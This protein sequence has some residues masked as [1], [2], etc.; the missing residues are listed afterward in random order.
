[1]A[2]EADEKLFRLLRTV[3]LVLGLGTLGWMLFQEFGDGF[4]PATVERRAADRAFEDGRY[5]QAYN[6]FKEAD[7]LA[8][9][10]PNV[11]RGMALSLMQLGRHKES[12]LVF[13]ELITLEPDLAINYANRGIL[14]DRMGRY[15]KAVTDYQTALS[16]DPEQVEGPGWFTRFLRNQSEPPPGV[17]DR[18]AYIL[19]QLEKPEAERVMHVEDI[20]AAQRPFKR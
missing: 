13:N 11:L 19:A 20:D 14:F 2:P 4:D 7:I 12:M 1:M 3:A 5:A 10:D 6:G 17:A 18:L 9:N 16:I 15:E 8:P